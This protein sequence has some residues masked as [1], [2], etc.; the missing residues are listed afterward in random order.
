MSASNHRS[1]GWNDDDATPDWPP[2]ET[3]EV[4]AL[5]S[6]FAALRGPSRILWRSPRPFS[7]AARVLTPAGERFVKRHHRRVRTPAALAEEHAFIAHLRAQ[8]LPVPEV[9][10]DDA[11]HTAIGRGDWTYEVHAAAG[12]VDLYRDTPS[13][14]PLAQPTHARN[15]GRMLARLHRAAAGFAAPSRSTAMLVARDD[16]LRA[17]DLVQAIDAQRAQR[18]ALAA[19]LAE[20]RD[21]RADLAPLAARHRQLQPRIA[22]LPR[23]W[24]HGDWHASNLFWDGADDRAEVVTILDFGLCAPTFA[25]YDLATAIERNAIAWLH[26][27]ADTQVAFPDTARALMA[28]YAELL[29]LAPAMRETLAALLPLV[30]VDFALSEVDYFLGVLDAPAQADLAWDGFLLGHAAWFSTA[31]GRALLDAIATP[32]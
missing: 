14:T 5:L 13:W 29:P 12:G 27:Y 19:Y 9:V 1:H 20:R 2:L 7:A 23:L 30:H 25:L 6:G 26:L 10:A 31:P 22:A 17:T 16:V 15:A 18:P 3:A 8:G 24:T 21:W 4:E 28:G 32:D 11:G